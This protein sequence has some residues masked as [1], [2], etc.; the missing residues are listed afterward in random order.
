MFIIV[1]QTTPQIFT[2]YIPSVSFVLNAIPI[3]VSLCSDMF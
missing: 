3:F 2:I 1:S